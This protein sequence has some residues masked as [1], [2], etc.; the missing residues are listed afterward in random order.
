M[1]LLG[2]TWFI[3]C[4]A[5]AGQAQ[6]TIDLSSAEPCSAC[7]IGFTRIGTIGTN[8]GEGRLPGFPQS[9]AR[10]SQGYVWLLIAEEERHL[11]VFDSVGGL[12]LRKAMGSAQLPG[13]ARVVVL[14]DTVVVG[15]PAGQQL[16]F[17]DRNLRP[18]GTQPVKS[19]FVD[20]LRGSQG[21]WWVSGRYSSPRQIGFPLHVVGKDGSMIRSFGEAEPI[22]VVERV[23]SATWLASNRSDS[24]WAL[25]EWHYEL[26]KWSGVGAPVRR[27]VRRPRWFDSAFVGRQSYRDGPPS[28]AHG[29]RQDRAGRLWVALSVAAPRWREAI[30]IVKSPDGPMTYNVKSIDDFMDSVIEVIDPETGKLL[31]SAKRPE[32]MYGLIDDRVMASVRKTGDSHF[33]DLWRVTLHLK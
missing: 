14:A 28:A 22:R 21:T 18:I 15:D 32:L 12:V 27:I 29:I 10:D 4:L 31:A 24:F 5:S 17:Y 8:Q 20:I 1:R 3:A 23:A 6:S 26:T 11:F 7:R 16:I 25:D 30:E 2:L 19:G 9:I 33:V 13:K